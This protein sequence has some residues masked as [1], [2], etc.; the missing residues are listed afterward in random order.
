MF[1]CVNAA[2]LCNA[3]KHIYV[4]VCVYEAKICHACM[5]VCMIACVYVVAVCHTYTTH[6]FMCGCVRVC[7][8]STSHIC[9]YMRDFVCVCGGDVLYSY[10][11]MCA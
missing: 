1:V 6:K 9:V 11:C 8:G 4:I 7:G 2:V 3:S 10:A 5:Y